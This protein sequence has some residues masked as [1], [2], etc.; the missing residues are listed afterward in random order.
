MVFLV[1]LARRFSML[2]RWRIKRRYKEYKEERRLKGIIRQQEKKYAPFI[3]ACKDE[4]SEDAVFDELFDAVNDIELVL[5]Q[6]KMKKLTRKATSL[7][8]E[9]PD[10]KNEEWYWQRTSLEGEPFTVLTDVGEAQLRT[11]IRKH[12]RETFEWWVKIISGLTGLI[13]TLIGLIAVLKK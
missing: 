8:I 2:L 1:Y 10:K 7:G 4:A 12:R 5:E 9:V 6:R 13:G 11:L 3:A